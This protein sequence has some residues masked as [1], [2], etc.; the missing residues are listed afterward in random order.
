MVG[1]FM[2]IGTVGVIP[3]LLAIHG[4]RTKSQ[5]FMDGIKQLI[6]MFVGIGL[7]AY[8]PLGAI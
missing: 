8:I 1:G 5:E 2:Y 4:T 3:E 6:A 7:M